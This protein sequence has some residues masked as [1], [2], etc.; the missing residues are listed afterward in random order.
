MVACGC[1]ILRLVRKRHLGGDA[2][3]CCHYRHHLRSAECPRVLALDSG[4]LRED[5][6]KRDGVSFLLPGY[7]HANLHL[8]VKYPKAWCTQVCSDKLIL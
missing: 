7:L 8:Q 6:V 1:S 2:S 5:K 3:G 4:V